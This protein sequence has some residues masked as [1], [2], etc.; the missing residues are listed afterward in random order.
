MTTSHRRVLG[1]SDS[2]CRPVPECPLQ[3]ECARYQ[4]ALPQGLG[5]I[6]GNFRRNVIATPTGHACSW[7]LSAMVSDDKLELAP[8][9]GVKPPI[10]GRT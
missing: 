1:H 4:S 10:G 9:K 6:M 2:R 5:A 7:F 8:S 3:G